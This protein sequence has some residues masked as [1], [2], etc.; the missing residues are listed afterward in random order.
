MFTHILSGFINTT[1]LFSS[2]G[3]NRAHLHAKH[4]V[5]DSLQA[6]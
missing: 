1:V 5:S 3:N 6:I 2:F 4:L